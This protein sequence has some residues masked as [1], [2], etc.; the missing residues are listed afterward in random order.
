MVNF[1][2]NYTAIQIKNEIK[3]YFF[4]KDFTWTSTNYFLLVCPSCFSHQRCLHAWLFAYLPSTIIANENNWSMFKFFPVKSFKKEQ[5][6]FLFFTFLLPILSMFSAR[7]CQFYFPFLSFLLSVWAKKKV[8]I[9]DM[10]HM[11]RYHILL[12]E[13]LEQL[14]VNS[15]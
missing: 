9:C 15:K 11:L 3:L 4:L 5:F 10:P 1:L 6:H 7:V 14:M 13:H 8:W 12:S 2:T